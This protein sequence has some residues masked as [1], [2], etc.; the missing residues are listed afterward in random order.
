MERIPVYRGRYEHDMMKD[1]EGKQG[2]GG[3]LIWQKRS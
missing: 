2:Q 1:N 3:R